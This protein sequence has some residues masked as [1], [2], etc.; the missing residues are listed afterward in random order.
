MLEGSLKGPAAV[1]APRV[2]LAALP[3]A[4]HSSLWWSQAMLG[5]PRPPVA[6]SHG[7]L[8]PHLCARWESNVVPLDREGTGTPLWSRFTFFS[9]FSFCRGVPSTDTNPIHFKAMST[10]S[11]DSNGQARDLIRI[12]SRSSK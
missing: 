7:H 9:I 1:A 12:V 5:V 2:L 6:G 10:A 3:P 8:C 4:P 11:P